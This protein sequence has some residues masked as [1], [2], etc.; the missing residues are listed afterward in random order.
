MTSI[1]LNK[2][3]NNTISL[4]NV[5]PPSDDSLPFHQSHITITFGLPI[6]QEFI[7]KFMF[8]RMQKHF[9]NISSLDGWSF[10][11]PDHLVEEGDPHLNVYGVVF[12]TTDK[13]DF[14]VLLNRFRAIEIENPF[15]RQNDTSCWRCVIRS[16][17]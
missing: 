6:S 12:S 14:D 2:F 10:Y 17:P 8:S 9:I 16:L 15:Q 11:R 7:M 4:L 13:T 1:P 5:W 3:V